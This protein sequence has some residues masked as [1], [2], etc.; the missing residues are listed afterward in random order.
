MNYI[1]D[2]KTHHRIHME[3][4]VKAWKHKNV[5]EWVHLFVHTLDTTS[6]N[7]YTETELCRGTE[8]CSLLIEGF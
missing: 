2:G 3:A 6:K 4:C 7:W 8:T 1:Y 5:D